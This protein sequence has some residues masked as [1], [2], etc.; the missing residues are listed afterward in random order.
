MGRLHPLMSTWVCKHVAMDNTEVTAILAQIASLLETGHEE[1]FAVSVRNALSGSAQT[2][3]EFLRSNELW[4]GAGSIADQP[5]AGR[6]TQ[7]KELEKLL[8][9]LGRLSRD[10]PLLGGITTRSRFEV[11]TIRLLR[12]RIEQFLNSRN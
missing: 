9:P 12:V 2:L 6:S 4:G 11:W 5:F 3:E 10:R 7:R 8:I 1:P